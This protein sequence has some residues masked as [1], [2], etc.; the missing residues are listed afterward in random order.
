MQ[1]AFAQT[2]QRLYLPIKEGHD[3]LL[4]ILSSDFTSFCWS[5]FVC[6]EEAEHAREA[7]RHPIRVVG[8]VVVGVTVVVDIAEVG[9]V[10]R[11][12]RAEPPVVSGTCFTDHNLC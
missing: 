7:E 11:I 2:Y 9:G 5:Y 3:L 4:F 12:R 1:E 10:A 8:V 6:Q